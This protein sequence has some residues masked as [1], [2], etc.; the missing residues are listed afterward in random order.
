MKS[1]RSHEGCLTIN[2]RYSPGVCSEDIR[3]LPGA[4][5]VGKG[6]IF[7][8]AVSVCGHC[9]RDIVL[10]PLRTRERGHCRKCDDY[11]CDECTAQLWRT[12]ICRTVQRRIDEILESALKTGGFNPWRL[13]KHLLRL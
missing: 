13:E 8:S 9:Q 1:K 11:I 7:K 2:H 12:G 5:A 3:H 4:I 10:M 6:Q